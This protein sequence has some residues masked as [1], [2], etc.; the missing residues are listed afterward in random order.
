MAKKYKKK[1]KRLEERYDILNEHTLDITDDNEQYLN[2]LRYL[3]AFIDWKNLNEEF[4]YFK[5]NA[6]EKYDEDLPFSRLT[7]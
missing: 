1:Y 6:Y 3:E 4:L 7:L 2:D 5:N